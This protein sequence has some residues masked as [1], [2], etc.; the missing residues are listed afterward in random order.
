MVDEIGEV[1][2]DAAGVVLRHAGGLVVDL[3]VEHV[4]SRHTARFF[5][6]VGRRV[7]ALVTLG[8]KR[9]PSSLRTVPK[10]VH[11]RPRRSDWLALWIGILSW[12]ALFMGIGIGVS[13]FL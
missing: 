3:T 1:V 9:I 5:H 7:I 11:A 8:G 13:H 6:G 10:G 4:F 12:I 2:V